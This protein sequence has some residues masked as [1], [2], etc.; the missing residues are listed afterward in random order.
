MPGLQHSLR[1]SN[2]SHSPFSCLTIVPWLPRGNSQH[3]RRCRDPPSCTEQH[4]GSARATPTLQPK[5][6]QGKKRLVCRTGSWLIPHAPG[7]SQRN[8][9]IHTSV[10]YQCFLIADFLYQ[11]FKCGKKPRNHAGAWDWHG[12][13]LPHGCGSPSPPAPQHL[14]FFPHRPLNVGSFGWL[15][16]NS[17]GAVPP[18]G[19][20]RWG[21]GGGWVLKGVWLGVRISEKKVGKTSSAPTASLV[22][23]EFNRQIQFNG[24]VF[25]SSVLVQHRVWLRETRAVPLFIRSETQTNSTGGR[26][27]LAIKKLRTGCGYP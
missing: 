1:I 19:R 13:V 4:Q 27:S 2:S 11:L 12:W 20:S 10:I 5:G 18:A 17:R 9:L 3:W 6:E 15:W 14:F 23:V 16:P 24:W 21:W 22:S 25:P 7:N 8:F 26:K